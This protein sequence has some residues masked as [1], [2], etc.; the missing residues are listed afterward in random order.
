MND[1][2]IKIISYLNI[3]ELTI[4]SPISEVVVKDAYKKLA[5]IYHPDVAKE[6][7][8]DGKKFIE[9]QNA[10][11]YLLNNISYVN[12]LIRNGFS[13]SSSYSTSNDAYERW[14]Q[15]QEFQRRQ[16]EEEE[17]KKAAEEAER[18]RQEEL[19]R[20]QEAEEKAR[21]EKEKKLREE[22]ARKKALQDRKEKAI[23]DATDLSK[24]YYKE[25]YYEADFAK[26][27]QYI[28]LFFNYIN[29]ER[30]SSIYD[31]NETYDVLINNINSIKTIA[32]QIKLKKIK[33]ISLFVSSSVAVFVVFLILL[34]N[35]FIPSYRY[36]KAINLYNDKQYG[37]AEEI[38]S[39]LGNYKNS[40]TYLDYIDSLKS[41]DNKISMINN[42]ILHNEDLNTLCIKI[43]NQGGDVHFQYELDGGSLDLSSKNIY[44]HYKSANKEGYSFISWSLVKKE[45]SKNSLSVLLTLKANYEPINYD[46]IYNLDGGLANN[47]KSYTIESD[48]FKLNN[49][50]KEG[51]RFIGWQKEGESIVTEELIIAK[52]TCGDIN[53]T[54]K[55]EP[56]E[57]TISFNTISNEKI[58]DLIVTYDS[59]Y[60]LP[61]LQKLGYD[62]SWRYENQKI[63][64]RGVWSISNNITL[65]ANWSIIDYSITYNLDG[66]DA[67][68]PNEY[69]IESDSFALNNPSK[70]GYTFLGWTANPY[71]SNYEKNVTINQG[72]YGNLC[73]YANWEINKYKLTIKYSNSINEEIGEEINSKYYNSTINIPF[74]EGYEA[75]SET[76][77]P[78]SMPAN[79]LVVYIK[80][81]P[82]N[83][84]INYVLNGGT[85][86]SNPSIYTIESEDIVLVNPTRIGYEFAGWLNN[87]TNVTSTQIKIPKGSIG[88]LQYEAVW[89]I[90][91]YKLTIKSNNISDID[92]L[93][94][95]LDYNSIIPKPQMD[96][97][98]FTGW[99][100][101]VP[102]KMPANDLIL[103]ANWVTYGVIYS[104]NGKKYVNYGFYP[105]SQV[106]NNGII[107]LLNELSAKNERGYYEYNY[108]EYALRD[109]KWYK[110]E[111][112]KW[113]VLKNE[114]NSYYLLSE[115]I[116]DNK[117]IDANFSFSPVVNTFYEVS[118]LNI[119][120]NNDFY[121]SAFNKDDRNRIVKYN[122]TNNYVWLLSKNEAF[123]NSFG[124][125][126]HHVN[127]VY[128]GGDFIDACSMTAYAEISAVHTSPNDDYGSWW[129]RSKENW[130]AYNMVSKDGK[131]GNVSANATLGIR[132][133]I[134]LTIN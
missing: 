98:A 58:N 123:D 101:E 96:N 134:I 43:N 32:Q 124:L 127:G 64:N 104:E 106:T 19:R 89:N 132:P 45:L 105:I 13:Q 1:E 82:I 22:Q 102:N 44:G 91:Q 27:N 85:V 24:K 90:C 57:Y 88:D 7:Y 77:F 59:N 37:E 21:K 84:S 47:Y 93:E 130:Y 71:S 39:T 79:D 17:K 92:D 97:Y 117:V 6:R 112:I 35:V 70:E 131:L 34:F 40:S 10:K 61:I 56:L 4:N 11:E 9:L 30:Y 49:P 3:M 119:W 68:N 2:I 116:L 67:T 15:E 121:L 29:N 42:V 108:C 73:F 111:P 81:V 99:N 74:K 53:I 28:L 103:S 72:N 109:S 33:K 8:K 133:V 115:Y 51:Y 20:K 86:S 31:I 94:L 41:F 114:G 118:T 126:P 12:S 78:F 113:K 75:V 52:G 83:Y 80:W 66:G 46:I 63:D 38:F 69:S 100:G 14:K 55:Y 54:A 36:N 110:V 62:F 128:S 18:K 122:E 87:K 76:R 65:E 25:D 125:N 60:S 95:Y 107:S 120:L 48:T 26:I 5:Q 23:K 129:L 50:T 16:K